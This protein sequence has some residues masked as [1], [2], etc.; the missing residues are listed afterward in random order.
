[1]GEAGA[2][3]VPSAERVQFTSSGTEARLMAMRLARA[4]TG[5]AKIARFHG[6]F[7]GWHDPGWAAPPFDGSL[8]PGCCGRPRHR[9]WCRPAMSGRST[10]ARK[11]DDIAEVILEP[12]GASWGQVPLRPGFAAGDTRSDART[13]VVL[14]L[15]EV[16]TGF[17]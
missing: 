14:I 16:I 17:R 6:H 2:E 12:T 1:M 10:A 7:H 4:Y 15:D 8:P 13:G 9:S 5:K 11:S 3:L